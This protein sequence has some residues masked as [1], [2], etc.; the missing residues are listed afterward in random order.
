ME[1][2]SEQRRLEREQSN[3][4][5]E[6]NGRTCAKLFQVNVSIFSGQCLSTIFVNEILNPPVW[7]MVVCAGRPPYVLPVTLS[8]RFICFGSVFLF[9]NDPI[10]K[11]RSLILEICFQGI[12]LAR[13]L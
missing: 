13:V 4:H 12:A 6:E 7:M 8:Q 11:T 1:M 9:F 10:L 3:L 2:N 5:L